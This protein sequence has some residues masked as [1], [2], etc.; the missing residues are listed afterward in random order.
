MTLTLRTVLL[1]LAVFFAL[2]AALNVPTGRVSLLALAVACL[3]GAQV[4]G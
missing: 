4:V 2:V 1:L 3:A